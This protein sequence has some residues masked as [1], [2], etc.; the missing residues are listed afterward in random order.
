MTMQSM[1]TCRLFMRGLPHLADKY[2]R[3]HTSGSQRAPDES[4]HR[5]DFFLIESE[6]GKPN[7]YHRLITDGDRRWQTS[8]GVRGAVNRRQHASARGNSK[9][10]NIA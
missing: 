7:R 6:W 1:L 8:S 4:L 5:P 9:D 2:G 3:N 10:R